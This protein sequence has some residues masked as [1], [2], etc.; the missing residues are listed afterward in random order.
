MPQASSTDWEMT[1]VLPLGA[2]ASQLERIEAQLRLLN[3]KALDFAR[4]RNR[5]LQS[6]V[7][8]RLEK[9]RDTLLSVAALVSDIGSDVAPERAGRSLAPGDDEP[10]LLSANAPLDEGLERAVARS[11]PPV[12]KPLPERDD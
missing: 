6:L 5:P 2:V 1:L 8:A 12:R 9:I 4:E 7:D 3:M 11:S 10:V